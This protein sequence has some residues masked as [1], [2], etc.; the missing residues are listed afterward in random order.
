M[1]MRAVVQDRYGPPEVLRIDEVE[2]PVPKEDEVL[3]RVRA[4]TVTQTDTHARAA[5]PFFWRFIAGLRR[6]K[7]RTLGVE[8]AGVVE[9][10]GAAVSEFNVGDEVFGGPS[11]WFGTH[12][13]F[14]CIRESAPL[15]HMPA[16]MSFD[17]AAAVCDGAIQALGALR[18]ADVQE[19][20]RI[21]I[22]G[23][24]GSLGTAAVQLAKHLGAHVTAVC[25]TK[26][27]ELVRSLGAD[28]VVDYQEVDFTKNGRAYDAII[29]AVGKYSFLRGRRS[30]KR[31]GVYIATDLGPFM[32][33]TLVMG[34][35]TRWIGSRRARFAGGR[36][37]KPDVV[38]LKALIEAGAFR[39]VIDRRYPLEQV[40]EAHRYVET[41]Q[42]V[43]NV[44]LTIGGDGT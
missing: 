33:E 41:W 31:G 26:S 25:G 3:I 22:Y 6:P 4:T 43:G 19:G 21:V 11:T 44:V 14:I 30:L 24:S 18:T 10:V 32:L 39:A 12:A 27:I 16:G 40:A 8:F 20:Q 37:N 1:T 36:R 9:A 2:R 38:F 42:K 17:E 28:E 15:A 34:I 23:A 7:W 29:D 13:E 35:A 5:R